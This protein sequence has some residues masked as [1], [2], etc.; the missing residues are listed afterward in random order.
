[1]NI[2]DIPENYVQEASRQRETLIERVAERDDFLMEKYI[3][4]QEISESP[5][6]SGRFEM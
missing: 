6:S 5:S 3:D 2:L 4:G 1:M